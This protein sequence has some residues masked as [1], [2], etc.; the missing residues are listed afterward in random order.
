MDTKHLGKK[1]IY[2]LEKGGVKYT[3]VTFARK[4]QPKTSKVEGRNFPTIVHELTIFVGECKEKHEVYLLV[5]KGKAGSGELKGHS[6]PAEVQELLEEFEDVLPN[7][8]PKRLPSMRDIQ[9]HIN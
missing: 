9:H 4:N 2:Q 7:D 5:V 6:I 3:L 1:N 8:L